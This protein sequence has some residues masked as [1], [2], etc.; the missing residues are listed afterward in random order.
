MTDKT[1]RTGEDAPVE[2]AREGDELL[3]ELDKLGREIGR[4]LK[5]AWKSDERKEIEAEVSKGIDV[6]GRELGKLARDAND[7]DAAKE[8]KKGAT[9]VGR[10]IR[11]GLL[12]GLRKINEE[13]DKRDDEEPSS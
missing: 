5:D 7:S 10:E 6:A 1:D 11:D 2:D 3:E 13:L 9:A 4:G 12:S 8:L